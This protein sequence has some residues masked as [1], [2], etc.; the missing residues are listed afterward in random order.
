MSDALNYLIAARPAAMKAYFGF[1][2]EAGTHLD[3]RMRAMISI[4]T[5]VAA[6]TEDGFRQYLS[7]GLQAGLTAN[8]IIDGLLMA[9]P[10]LGLTK[11]T[12]A[13]DLLL[14]MDIPEFRVEALQSTPETWHRLV[15]V[16][17]LPSDRTVALA[18]DGRD[19]FV[20]MMEGEFRVFDTRCPHQVTHIPALALDGDRITC[21]RHGWVFD[22]RSA[23]CIEKGDRGLRQFPSRVE[24]GCLYA[25][26]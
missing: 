24:G 7:R 1:L 14:Q 20:R 6:Q 26:W 23:S 2:R 10:A 5:K 19:L 22:A 11:V 21:P 13:V 8:E 12:W 9:F 4:I 15:E 17:Q 16:A 25:C 18:A 3:P